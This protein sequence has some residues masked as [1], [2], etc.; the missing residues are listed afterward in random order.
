MSALDQ[1]RSQLRTVGGWTAAAA[2]TIPLVLTIAA[3]A[4]WVSVL[5]SLVQEYALHERS[6]DLLR[7]SLFVVAG[8]AA[9][10]LLGRRLGRR[11]PAAALGLSV[12]TAV[13]GVALAPAARTALL[14]NG[15]AGL[16]DML[17]ANPGGL[18]AGLALLR[19][20]A[21]GHAGLPLPED[22]LIRLLAGGLLIITFAAVAG[23]LA[24]EAWRGP[25]LAGALA[26]GLV[27]A[28]SA[29]LALAFTRQA[30]A[31][32]DIAAG[33]Q[34]NPI[35]LVSLLLVMGSLVLASMALSGQ[36][37][38]SLEL[39]IAVIAAPLVI[40][41]LLTGWTRRGLRIF[42]GLLAGAVI[43]ASVGS[44]IVR[45][46][47]ANQGGRGGGIG[48]AGSPIDT[49]VAIGVTGAA[50]IAIVLVVLLLVRLWMRRL[51]VN[52]DDVIEERYVDR[53]EAEEPRPRRRQRRPFRRQPTDAVA[54]YRALL[55]ELADR[56]GVRREPAETPREHADRLRGEGSAGIQL[57]LLAA[58][59]AL[60][61]FGQLPLSAAEN[62]RA[63]SRWRV[64]R[65]R[66]H[67]N[68]QPLAEETGPAPL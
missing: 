49:A 47:E 20:I 1:T 2:A 60:A 18:L 15:V 46:Q 40:A 25:F 31:A 57:N 14:D 61:S 37:R 29:I 42:I 44:A 45:I 21:W 51:Q 64:L 39:G 48:V 68:S 34:R 16:A 27:F 32:G 9:A 66:L 11:W 43:L 10:R 4:A 28:G 59:Y 58:D 62:R 23:G 19:G 36:V 41:G 56:R 67:A 54:A 13:V 63:V 22:R 3:E 24:I 30:I 55:A 5:A 33:W 26:D 35:W 8:F 65:R 17:A 38:P 12:A 7:L 6:F 53:T 50:L 52:A